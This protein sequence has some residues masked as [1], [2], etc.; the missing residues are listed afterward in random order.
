M[1]DKTEILDQKG[2]MKLIPHR[3]PFLLIDKIVE[4]HIN[5]SAIGIKKVDQKENYFMGHFPDY[6]VLPGVLIIEALAQTAACLISYSNEDYRSKKLVFLTGVEE[7]KF[8]KAVI[9]NC[10]LLLDVKLIGRRK[11]FF[12]FSGNALVDNQIMT[13]AKFSAMLTV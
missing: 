11:N 9:P 5:D 2:I 8:K 12:K 13:T 1:V 6:P 7:A 10:K 3:H 4:I